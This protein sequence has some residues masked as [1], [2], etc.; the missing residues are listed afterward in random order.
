MICGV[1]G[2]ILAGGK[3]SRMGSNKALLPFRGGLFIEAIHRHLA[4]LFPEMILVTN[5]PEQYQ[6][7]P[8]RKVADLFPGMGALAGLHAGLAASSAPAIFAV[9][10]DMPFLNTGLIRY[11]VQRR[12][13][14]EVILPHGP[15]GA[16]PLHAVYGKGC[17]AAMEQTLSSGER[18]IAAFFDQISLCRVTTG[19]VSRFD[20]GF[21][22]FDNINTPVDYY[23]L[24]AAES[25]PDNRQRQAVSLLPCEG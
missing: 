21:R 17:L 18:R 24:R 8:C 13:E 6:G 10:C 7:I 2:V 23:H 14:G 15:G 11:L 25:C 19:E 20:P 3:S 16:E 22:S 12:N 5:T 4:E 1:A 9:A